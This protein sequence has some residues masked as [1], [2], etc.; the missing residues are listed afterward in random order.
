MPPG[1]SHRAGRPVKGIRASGVELRHRVH[2]V[3]RVHVHGAGGAVR[4][5]H[6]SDHD[7]VELPLSVPFALLSLLLMNENFSV[8]YSSVGILVLFGIVKKNSILQIDH[9]KIAAAEGMPRLRS[10]LCRVVWTGCGPF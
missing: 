5:L 4:E 1:Y 9:I 2:A 8:I 6:R 7:P 10:H 3:D